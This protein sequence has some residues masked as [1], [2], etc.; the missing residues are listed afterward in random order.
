MIACVKGGE[1]PRVKENGKVKIKKSLCC[2]G[3]LKLV[4]EKS[5]RITW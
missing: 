3:K 5:L 4:K 2:S 1:R